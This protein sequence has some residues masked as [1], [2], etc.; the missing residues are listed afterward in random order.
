MRFNIMTAFPKDVDAFLNI[1][2]LGRARKAGFIDVRCWGIRDY[3]LDRHG[4]IDDYG[5]GDGRGML[6]MPEPVCRCFD[7]VRSADPE[8][9]VIYLSPK[10]KKLTQSLAKKLL[11]YPSLTFL[12]GHYEGIDQRALDAIVD[13][14]VSLGDYVITGGELGAM[15]MVDCIARMVPGVLP[16]PECY[17][18]ESIYSGLLEYPQYTRP[19]VYRGVAVPEI[20]LSGNHEN[21]RRWRLEQSLALT[22]ERRKDLYRRYIKKKENK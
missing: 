18:D 10:G 8:T 7:A 6:M 17:E 3:T 5:Y 21:V 15:V 14:E 13:E 9:H 4:R 22:R 20:L 1:S 2:I 19:P 12:C 11:R 16:S